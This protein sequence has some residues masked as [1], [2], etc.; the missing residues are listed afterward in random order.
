MRDPLESQGF[1]VG[2]IGRRIK[3]KNNS[4]RVVGDIG[5]TQKLRSRRRGET[6]EQTWRNQN[7]R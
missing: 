6:I 3:Y 7:E 5:S 1:W 4:S 2:K